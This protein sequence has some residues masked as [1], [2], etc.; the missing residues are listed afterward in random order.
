[1]FGQG[2]NLACIIWQGVPSYFCRSQQ[3]ICSSEGQIVCVSLH[4]ECVDQN[5]VVGVAGVG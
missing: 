4:N 1:M 5:I 2:S 3:V